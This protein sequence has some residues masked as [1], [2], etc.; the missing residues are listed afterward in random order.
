MNIK[1]SGDEKQ[2]AMEAG[3]VGESLDH[4]VL[5]AGVESRD[6]SDYSNVK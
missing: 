5:N 1:K 2:P 4:G 3:K 6:R